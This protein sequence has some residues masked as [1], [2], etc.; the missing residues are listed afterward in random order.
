MK[1]VVTTIYKWRRQI[2]AFVLIATAV[3]ALAAWIC[4]KKY[5]SNAVLFPSNSFLTDKSHLFNNNIQQLYSSLGNSDDLDHLFAIASS[6]TVLGFIIDSLHLV[7]HYNLNQIADNNTRAIK[8]LKRNLTIMKSEN[9]ELRIEAWDR[10]NNMAASI[11]ETMLLKIQ[12]VS[13]EILMQANGSAIKALKDNKVG[14]EDSSNANSLG[15]LAQQIEISLKATP[16]AFVILEKPI[17]SLQPGKP[18][19]LLIILGSF[20]LSILFALIAV[21]VIERFK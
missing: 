17:L 3:A 12:S 21:Q 15:R 11:L 7:D 14:V 4:P 19:M 9:G 2:I 16:P 6:S 20:F 1:N 10:D 13:N 8:M 18:D 5:V